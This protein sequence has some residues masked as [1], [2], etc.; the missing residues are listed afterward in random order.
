MLCRLG[1]NYNIQTELHFWNQTETNSFLTEFEF[2]FSK[3]EWKPNRNFK[4]SIPHIPSQ[5]GSELA[6]LEAA[7]CKCCLLQAINSKMM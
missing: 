4:K 5:H 1:N 7:G 6:T 3:T 2:F